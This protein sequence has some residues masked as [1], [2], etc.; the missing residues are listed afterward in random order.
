MRSARGLHRLE[1]SGHAG[2]RLFCRP[3]RPNCL[4]R[5][6]TPVIQD[7][8]CKILKNKGYTLRIGIRSARSAHP[9]TNLVVTGLPDDADLVQTYADLTKGLHIA[10]GDK[11]DYILRIYANESYHLHPLK[12]G[13]IVS[14]AI[15]FRE[16]LREPDPNRR[17]P[18]ERKFPPSHKWERVGDISLRELLMMPMINNSLFN[19]LQRSRGQDYTW[20]MFCEARDKKLKETS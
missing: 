3:C 1:C 13:E 11:M 15:P 20:K 9:L 14:K 10:K 4:L 16:L 5:Y 17:F 19:S 12:D 8:A 7:L 18:L 2:P 6:V